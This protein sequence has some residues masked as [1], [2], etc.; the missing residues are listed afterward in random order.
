[1]TRTMQRL[2]FRIVLIVTGMAVCAAPSF[3]STVIS[4]GNM[5]VNT[6]QTFN[7]NVSISGVTDLFSWQFDL[8]FD[9]TLLTANSISEGPFL[10]TGGSPTTSRALSTTAPAR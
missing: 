5:V 9:H 2:M 3:A 4:A 7:L 1:M 8:S 6:G 10:K